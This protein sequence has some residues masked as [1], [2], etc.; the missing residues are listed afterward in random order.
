[1]YKVITSYISLILWDSGAASQ[2]DSIFSGQSL[3]S[4]RPD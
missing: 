2:N 3:L 4:N 1:M